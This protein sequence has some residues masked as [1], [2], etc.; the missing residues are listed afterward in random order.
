VSAASTMLL[1]VVVPL[2]RLPDAERDGK[3]CTKCGE[4]KPASEFNR[5]ARVKSGLTSWCKGCVNAASKAAQDRRAEA[6]P[7][8]AEQKCCSHCGE[9]K[10]GTEFYSDPKRI[11][12]LSSRCK[13]C[14]KA[15][16]NAWA[17]EN[18]QRSRDKSS[19]WKKA[20][21][22][23]KRSLDALWRRRNPERKR[24]NDARFYRENKA[25]GR[26]R[27]YAENRRARKQG[28]AGIVSK[29]IVQRL[30]RLQ[31]GKCACCKKTL[32]RNYHL[33]HILPLV[34][35]GQ[36]DDR[37]LQL[38]R[39]KCNLQKNR[40]HPVQFMQERGFLL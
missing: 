30:L 33:D 12:G 27:L 16:S 24:A 6:N 35:G 28:A 11:D 10:A 14:T 9:T 37:N 36:H 13:V 32:G 7:P 18:R 38:L 26:Q 40:K 5:T 29:D 8:V 23:R 15:L 1:K 17:A 2:G 31:R 19:E 34:L 39:A 21:P 4:F 22:E 20:N 3:N 25:K